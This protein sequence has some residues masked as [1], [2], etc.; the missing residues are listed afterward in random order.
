[1]RGE[2]VT[3]YLQ[4]RPISTGRGT[5]RRGS[6][7]KT[8]FKKQ[9]SGDTKSGRAREQQKHEPQSQLGLSEATPAS[10]HPH[11]AK[12]QGRAG[13]ERSKKPMN[14]MIIAFLTGKK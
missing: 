6:P 9:K 3:T 13:N 7:K 8:G 11:L 4:T 2:A 14:A 1:M 12:A 10:T 5:R